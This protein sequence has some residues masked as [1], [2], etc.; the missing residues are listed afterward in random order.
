MSKQKPAKPSKPPRDPRGPVAVQTPPIPSGSVARILWVC[1]LLVVATLAVYWPVAGFQFINFD[2]HDYVVENRHVLAGLTW[3]GLGWALTTGHTANWHPLTWLSHMLDCQLFGTWAGGPHLVN[4]ALHLANAVLL[5]L[6]L[7]RLTGAFWRAAFVAALFALHPL[8]VESV[9]WIAERKDVLSTFFGFISLLFYSRFA[10]ATFV[11]RKSQ[12][13]NYWL[14]VGFFALGLMAKPMLVTWPFVLL[15]LD[16][17]PLKRVRRSGFNVQ[18]APTLNAGRGTRNWPGL[19]LEKIPYL[20][21]SAGSCVVTFLV[22]RAGGAVETLGRLSFPGRAGNALV[23]YARY[24]GKTFWPVDL[25]NPYPHPGAWPVLAV[26]LAAGLVVALSAGAF[27]LRRT[28]PYLVVGWFWFLGMLVPVIGLVQV[29]MQSMADRYTY[30]PLVGVFIILVWAAAELAARVPAGQKAICVAGIL[31]LLACGFR[32]A[33]QVRYWHDS[34]SLSRHAL[35]VTQDNET[36]YSNLG[37]YCLETGKLDEAA[38]DFRRALGCARGHHLKP[39]RVGQDLFQIDA[40]R[41]GTAAQLLN[42]LGISLAQQ[43]Q[44]AAAMQYYRAA[45]EL[46]PDYALAKYNVAHELADQQQYAEAISDFEAVA[47][48]R[49]EDVATRNV[50]AST[51]VRAGRVDDAIRTYQEALAIAPDDA[52]THNGL[53]LVLENAGRLDEALAQYEAALRADP[54]LLEVHNNLGS[55]L[56]K[57]GRLDEAIGHFRALLKQQPEYQRAQDNL[58]VALASKGELPEALAHLREAVRLQPDNA[59]THFN[60]GNVLALQGGFDAAAGEF[61]EALRLAPGL[62]PAHCNLGGVLLQ[63]GRRDEA[64]AQFREALRINPDYAPAAGQLR[65]LGE[66]V[67]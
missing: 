57:Q 5:F 7:R 33:D 32:T 51:L 62:V 10:E 67:P 42:N 19:V 12:I 43:G 65:N 1:L 16:F 64:V 28:R 49:P 50:L 30:V 61:R 4:L 9:A 14:S 60:L 17:W 59:Q 8:H 66:S 40:D 6:G 36:A 63:L 56:L 35:A 58:G 52:T 20:V 22:Q 34:G 23:S 15:L 44:V 25:A 3:R 46:D 39:V 2:D 47:A 53:G 29:G 26:L 21:L 41:A 13:V 11:N 24:L 31:A 54:K 18:S 55:V 45:L 37:N 38:A 48:A 27:L